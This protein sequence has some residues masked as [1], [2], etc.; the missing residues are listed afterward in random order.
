VQPVMNINIVLISIIEYIGRTISWPR[1]EL[2]RCIVN[3]IFI[4]VANSQSTTESSFVVIHRKTHKQKCKIHRS[5]YI[6][7]PVVELIYGHFRHAQKICNFM[8]LLIVRVWAFRVVFTNA[9]V[10]SV[11]DKSESV[12]E[13]PIHINNIIKLHILGVCRKCPWIN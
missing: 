7:Q 3:R 6:S 9:T 12:K 1:A 13:P 8:L 4:T 10:L 5:L 2:T 11:S